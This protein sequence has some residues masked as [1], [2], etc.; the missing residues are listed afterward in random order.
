[1]SLLAR[2]VVA[3][4]IGVLVTIACIFVGTVLASLEV[5]IA[6][7]VGDLLKRFAGVFGVLA[8]L[9]YAAAGASWA[10]WNRNQP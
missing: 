6:V 7:T 4:V 9:Y 8:F 5:A 2:I 10:P 3:V 1:M